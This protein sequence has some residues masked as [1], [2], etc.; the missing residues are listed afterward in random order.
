MQNI[1]N[2]YPIYEQ[3]FKTTEDNYNDFQLNYKWNTKEIISRENH[4]LV[5]VKLENEFL[6]RSR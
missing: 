5:K 4:N 3:L 6:L 2:Y 1:Q